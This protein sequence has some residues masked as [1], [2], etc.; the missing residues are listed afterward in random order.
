MFENERALNNALKLLQTTFDEF[1]LSINVGKTKT[2]ILNFQGSEDD[3][4][5]TISSLNNVG[6]DNVR[7]F[8]YLGS[9]IKFNEE[10]TVDSELEFRIDTAQAKLYEL[11]K[12]MFNHRIHLLTRIKLLNALVRSRHVHFLECNSSA[13]VPP[14][15]NIHGDD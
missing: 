9:N 12:K 6:L 11:R 7:V 15:C 1:G 5:A 4:P 8:K 10:N 14:E 3:Y 2:M 13:I